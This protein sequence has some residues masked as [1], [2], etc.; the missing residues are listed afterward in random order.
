M[1]P[2]FDVAIIGAGIVGAACAASCA[3]AGLTVVV[4]ERQ[5]IACGSTGSCMGHIV[6]LHDTEAHFSITA[7]SRRLWQQLIGELPQEVEYNPCGTI[8]LA[9]D[10][11]QIA[12]LRLEQTYYQQHGIEAHILDSNDLIHAE[13]LIRPD[14]PAGLYVPGDA[15]L[16]PPAAAAYLLEKARRH[17]AI[18][19]TGQEVINIA[20]D[21]TLTLRDSSRLSAEIVVN[22]AG[23]W[24]AD[25]CTDLPVYRRKGHLVVTDRYPGLLHHQLVELSYL[26]SVSDMHTAS[27]AFN[28][29]PRKTGQI[30]IGS[31][32]Q[33]DSSK[34][35]LDLPIVCRMLQ[36][37]TYFMPQLGRLDAIR[38]WAGHRP[39]TSDHLPLIGP[40]PDNERIWWATGHEGLGVT[41]SLATGSIIAAM[42]T[43]GPLEI[44]P[45][46]YLPTRLVE[47]FN[48]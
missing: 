39:T 37:A 26:K 9:T 44:S 24:S 29:Q 31:S 35:D 40:S 34:S 8:W 20:D 15:V 43:A 28:V 17:K 36:R 45:K 27:V 21:A 12:Q 14:L 46:P 19:L 48:V 41:T 33:S 5:Y 3:E 4:V 42:I 1:S 10:P 2:T 22:A 38:C 6:L 13:P 47:N 32:R 16:Y 7:F 23:C 25:L 18:V 30:L 11:Q